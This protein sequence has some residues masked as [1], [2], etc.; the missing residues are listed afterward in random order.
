MS[1]N[2]YQ[3][4]C[5][6]MQ[7]Q[8]TLW[9]KNLKI[10][11]LPTVRSMVQGRARVLISMCMES[12]YT[13]GHQGEKFFQFLNNLCRYIYVYICI[14]VYIDIYICIYGFQSP[15]N[16]VCKLRDWCVVDQTLLRLLRSVFQLINLV[17]FS[18]HLYGSLASCL[19]CLNTETGK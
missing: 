7:C 1:K 8:R 9:P 5:P 11:P 19:H 6:Q 2:D 10:I 4:N 17:P 15:K 16:A 3:G 18:F 13:C 12:F 14:Q